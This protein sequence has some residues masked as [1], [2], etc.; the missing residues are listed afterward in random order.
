MLSCFM[1]ADRAGK[2]SEASAVKEELE[3]EEECSGKRGGGGVRPRDRGDKISILFF[4]SFLPLIAGE[5][6]QAWPGRRV[7]WYSTAVLVPEV[8]VELD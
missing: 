8:N 7:G 3:M 5:S 1:Y 6:Q 4:R 2:T